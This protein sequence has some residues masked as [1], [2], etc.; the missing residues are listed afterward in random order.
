MS[1]QGRAR[2]TSHRVGGGDGEDA[3]RTHRLGLRMERF[4]GAVGELSVTADA[5]RNDS[6]DDWHVPNSAAPTLVTA[7]PFVQ[8]DQGAGLGARLNRVGDDGSE[9]TFQGSVQY[10][11][12]AVGDF[13]H[14]TRHSI[15]LDG[16]YRFTA[17]RH[18]LIVG[19]GVR[20][21]DQ[22]VVGSN[23]FQIDQENSRFGLVSAFVHDEIT[24]LPD[25]LTLTAGLK[26]EHHSW[27]G[28]EWQPN[29]RMA[30]QVARNH[31]LWGAVSEAS[32][33]PAR[34]EFDMSYAPL[35]F[36]ASAPPVTALPKLTRF[37][38][39]TAL[40]AERVRSY[41]LGYRGQPGPTTHVDVTAFLSRYRHMRTLDAPMLYVEGGWLVVD[42]ALAFK[43]HG[44]T[45]GLEAAFDWQPSTRWR[46][47]LSY[48]H[49]ETRV[50]ALGVSISDSASNFYM[51][52]VPRDQL[53]LHLT[54]KPRTGHAVDAVLRHVA[55]LVHSDD[56]RA[57][58][59]A[60]T[61]LD[62]QYGWRA[63]PSL[64]LAVTGRNLLDAHHQEFDRD[65]MP[66]VIREIERSVHF[67][68]QW[69]FD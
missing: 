46:T 16:Q 9:W 65:Y 41:E 61:E 3:W 14:E 58:V 55:E 59:A 44:I 42:S 52:R 31:M 1:Y 67:S 45:S 33:T 26:Y 18:D 13:L 50:D 4:L 36:P 10:V 8:R 68:A 43:G 35:A 38:N 34:V 25:E 15:D 28:N 20:Y 24:L 39:A 54:W 7:S 63:S 19:A 47:R 60:Y 12:K 6:E 11:D 69:A 29:V 22:S 56:D 30:W 40:R 27:T 21:N 32:R 5:Y 2:G 49:L 23:F 53:G 64:T 37:S 57:P 17:G 48:T 51:R 62:L 66:S